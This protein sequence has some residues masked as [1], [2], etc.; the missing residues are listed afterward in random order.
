VQRDTLEDDKLYMNLVGSGK[1]IEVNE[2]YVGD[3]LWTCRNDDVELEDGVITITGAT[4]SEDEEMD[5]D[6]DGEGDR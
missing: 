6:W 5:G 2:A 4:D 3:K 1:R